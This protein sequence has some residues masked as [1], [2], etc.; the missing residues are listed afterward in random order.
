MAELLDLTIFGHRLRHFRRERGLTLDQLG[1]LVGRPAPYL[2]QLENGKREPR[3]SFIDQLAV[4]LEVAPADLVSSQPPTRRAALEVAFERAQTSPLYRGLNLPAFRPS[5]AVPDEALDHILALFNALQRNARARAAS[6]EGARAVNAEMRFEMRE[7]DNYFPEIE[8]AA[9]EALAAIHWEGHGALSERNLMDLVAHFGFEVRRTQD[10]PASTRSVTDTRHNRIYIP[11]RNALPT[12]A[13]RTVIL[14]TLG[15]FVLGHDEPAGFGDFLRQRVE[16]NYFAGA[17]LAPEGAVVPFLNDAFAR[18]DISIEDVKEIFYISYEMAAHRFTNLAT[19]HLGMPVHF[20][21]ADEQ[22]I[23][24]KAYE[25]NSVPFPTDETGAIEGQRVCRQW[26]TRQVFE[27][28]DKFAV[29]Y[30]YTATASGSYWTVT[31]VEADRQPHH[32]ITVGVTA[33]YARYFRGADT[34]RRSVSRCPEGP[35]C[36]EPSTEMM[37]RWEQFAWPSS[38]AESHVLAAFPRGGFPG[39]D[40]TE[41]YDFLDRNAGV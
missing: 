37:Q 40:L 23:I 14:Q 41:V 15:H 13:A 22:G 25:N 6:V 9:R 31:H 12:R 30:Q 19:K 20:L 1:A 29:H 21:R 33:D 3:L 24:W 36:R 17:V 10:I 2:S 16:T 8:E 35:C 26:A 5:T 18:R 32:A 7:R 11:Q 34:K 38:R 4:A 39:V 27:S 28:D